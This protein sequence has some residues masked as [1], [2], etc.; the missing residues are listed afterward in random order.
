MVKVTRHKVAAAHGR[1]SRIRQM[2]LR[3]SGSIA[4]CYAHFVQFAAVIDR[5]K[6]ALSWLDSTALIA[7][8]DR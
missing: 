2:N 1:F 7:V 5:H 8:V 6:D 3:T 4:Q